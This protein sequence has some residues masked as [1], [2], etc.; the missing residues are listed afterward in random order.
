MEW[1]KLTNNNVL[2][3]QQWASGTQIR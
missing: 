2:N 1:I 3:C